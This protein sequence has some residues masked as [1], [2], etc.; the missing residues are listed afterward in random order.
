M[1]ALEIAFRMYEEEEEEEEDGDG[2]R[3]V[4]EP[5]K[6]GMVMLEWLDFERVYEV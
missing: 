1:K 6:V 3:M 4:I 5:E 2:E